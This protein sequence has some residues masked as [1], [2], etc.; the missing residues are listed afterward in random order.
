V[1]QRI[2]DAADGT[3]PLI[4]DCIAAKEGSVA[5]IAKIA[6]RGAKVAVLLPVIERDSS[7]TEDPLYNMDIETSANWAEGVDVR[8]VRT[9]FYLEASK[10]MCCYLKFIRTGC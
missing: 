9:H 6:K 5:H 8:G 3:V 2:L 4:L 1:V 10:T 7:E